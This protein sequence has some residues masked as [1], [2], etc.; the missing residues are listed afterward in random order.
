VKNVADRALVARKAQE[1]CDSFHDLRES[2][3]GRVGVSVSIGICI[4]PEDGASF[5]EIYVKADVALYAAKNKGKNTYAF[6]SDQL[7]QSLW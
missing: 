4:L 5:D 7:Q 3:G 6:Y 2:K 1:I